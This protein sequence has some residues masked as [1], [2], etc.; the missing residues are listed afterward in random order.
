MAESHEIRKTTLKNE[1]RYPIDWKDRESE[2]IF[3]EAFKNDVGYIALQNRKINRISFLVVL[4]A[5][6]TFAVAAESLWLGYVTYK[7]VENVEK[8]QQANM[9]ILLLV[10]KR[11][12]D[13][14]K[15]IAD[16]KD[17]LLQEDIDADPINPEQTIPSFNET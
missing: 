10:E 17:S 15:E 5:I 4:M 3:Q 8:T 6:I 16:I 11:L 13:M 14:A 9:E 2:N 12:N 1:E 7:S